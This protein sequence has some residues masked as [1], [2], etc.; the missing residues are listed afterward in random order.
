MILM[1]SVA[2]LIL[3]YLCIALLTGWHLRRENNFCKAKV[4]YYKTV[5]NGDDLTVSWLVFLRPDAD[6]EELKEIRMQ[7]IQVYN[8]WRQTVLTDDQLERLTYIWPVYWSA[9]FGLWNPAKE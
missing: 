8:Q 3:V 4:K 7:A 5:M 2:V 9:F 1:Q 6:E